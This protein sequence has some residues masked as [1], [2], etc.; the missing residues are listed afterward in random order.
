[1]TVDLD[2]KT[3]TVVMNAGKTLAKET[4]EK[5]LTGEKFKLVEFKEAEAKA[6]AKSDKPAPEPAP[7]K[8]DEPKKPAPSKETTKT[9]AAP[10]EKAKK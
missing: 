7:K 5:A 1:M 10:S 8:A 3:A 4:V 9:E 2:T 6:E